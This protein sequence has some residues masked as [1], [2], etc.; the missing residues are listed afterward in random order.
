MTT[1]SLGQILASY[2]PKFFNLRL[3]QT[4]VCFSHFGYSSIHLSKQ[5]SSRDAAVSGVTGDDV[6]SDLKI[7]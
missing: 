5:R 1:G 2:R 4:I 3:L 6:L 7:T